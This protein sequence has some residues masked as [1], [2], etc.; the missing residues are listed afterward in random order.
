MIHARAGFLTNYAADLIVPALLYVMI[1]GLA[2]RDR[3]PTLVRRLFGGTPERAAV[4]LFLASA[5]TEWTQR[6]WP[7]GPFP[8]RYDPLDIAAFGAGIVICYACDYRDD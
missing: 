1:R 6:Y 8:G 4:V 2:E 3:Q 5:G 7:K